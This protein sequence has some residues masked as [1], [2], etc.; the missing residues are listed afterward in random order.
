MKVLVCGSREFSDPFRANLAIIDRI[1]QLPL[2]EVIHG[3]ARGADQMAATAATRMGHPVTMFA[4]D[5]KTHGKRAGVIRN[6]E[7]LAQRPDLVLA[8]WNEESVGTMHT[9]TEAYKRKIPVE[10]VALK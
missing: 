8:F 7:M 10:I 2:C 3:G 1:A 6:L 5:W 9:L 4:A